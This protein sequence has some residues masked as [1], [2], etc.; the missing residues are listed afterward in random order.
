MATVN[1]GT[2]VL[3]LAPGSSAET[4]AKSYTGSPSSL[5]SRPNTSQ[6]TPS[7]KGC[8]PSSRTTATLFS[9]LPS[10][11]PIWQEIEGVRQYCHSR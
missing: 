1:P 11:H 4:T 6:T 10:V 3:R 8:T 2:W 7:S 5:R 9:M